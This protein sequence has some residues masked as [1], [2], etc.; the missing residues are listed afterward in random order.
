L[1]VFILTE[2][3]LNLGTIVAFTTFTIL[4]L[5]NCGAIMEKKRWIYNIEFLRV[6]SLL[7]IALQFHNY[8]IL[9]A[10]LSIVAVAA[11]IYY[12]PVQNSYLSLVYR[13]QQ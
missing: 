12:R 13:Y 11:L 4:T 8:A 9:L 5:I 7:A 1:F 10:V 6:I 3:Y 2:H